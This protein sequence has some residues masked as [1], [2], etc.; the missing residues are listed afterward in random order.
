[1]WLPVP[2]LNEVTGRDGGVL[3]SRQAE[4]PPLPK[5]ARSRATRGGRWLSRGDRRGG[6][7]GR[8]ARG[9]GEL[10]RGDRGGRWLGRGDRP[11]VPRLRRVLSRTLGRA[12]GRRGRADGSCDASCDA[13][14]DG[15]AA[16]DEVAFKGP[17]AP[18]GLKLESRAQGP[19][20]RYTSLPCGSC[21]RLASLIPAAARW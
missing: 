6:E 10:G 12:V 21:P 9:G 19:Y 8:G 5:G 16:G 3:V 11:P 1:V 13:G 4:G 2:L 17:Q 20:F 18:A 7:L 14:N 15:H